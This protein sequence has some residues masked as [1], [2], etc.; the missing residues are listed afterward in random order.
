MVGKAQVSMGDNSVKNSRIKIPKTHA[1]L[2]IIGRKSTQFQMNP[3][4]DVGRVGKTRSLGRTA[5]WTDGRTEGR[6]E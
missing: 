4:T 6:T 1:Q 2:H 3:M 5:G